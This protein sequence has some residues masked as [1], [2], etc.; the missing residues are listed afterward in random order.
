MKVVVSNK[1]I[2]NSWLI[3]NT[4]VT[5][6][7]NKIAILMTLII[8]CHLMQFCLFF[9]A[10]FSLSFR[11]AVLNFGKLFHEL[12]PIFLISLFLIIGSFNIL[13]FCITVKY[14]PV[15]ANDLHYFYVW[16]HWIS[17]LYLLTNVLD[18]EWVCADRL[19]DTF[20][21]FFLNNFSV[22]HNIK[23]LISRL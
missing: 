13:L 8:T 6:V 14:L 12:L 15:L 5:T 11:L 7:A 16:N 2:Y 18:I 19:F 4:F 23:L 22:F 21:K 20:A 10:L 9:L 17:I 3:I 1:I